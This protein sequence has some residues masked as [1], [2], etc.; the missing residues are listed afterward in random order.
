MSAAVEPPVFDALAS[1]YDAQFSHRPAAR[2]LRQRVQRFV[3]TEI[4]P[5][6]TVL[7][8]GCGTG[9]DTLWLASQGRSVI[10]TDPSS[11]MLESTRQKLARRSDDERQRVRLAAFDANDNALPLDGQRV[12]CVFSNFGALNCVEDLGGLF[13]RLT[14][15]L[16]PNALIV[17]VLMSRYC[18]LETL[19]HGLRGNGQKARRRWSGS[20]EF[21]VESATQ[22]IWYPTV[23]ELTR[24]AGPE[25]ERTAVRGIGV[26]VPPSEFFGVLERH[27]SLFAT[28]RALDRM[29]SRWWPFNRVGDHTLIAWRYRG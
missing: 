25:Y 24:A 13:Q 22:T 16:K 26:A 1:D 11:Q 15:V 18:W 17:W 6:A 14:P 9:E 3:S 8:I 19:G 7:E 20:A 21:A 12:D 2:W 5:S 4:E 23:A 28:G 29:L 27:P 10:A